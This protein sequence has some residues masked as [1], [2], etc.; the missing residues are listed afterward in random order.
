MIVVDEDVSPAMF[1]NKGLDLEESQYVYSCIILYWVKVLLC[2]RL[3]QNDRSHIGLHPTDTQ[4]AN[5]RQ[6]SNILLRKINAWIKVQQSYMPGASILRARTSNVDDD[7][8]KPEHIKLLLPS[9]VG[10]RAVCDDVLRNY[11][12]DHRIAQAND[13]LN[14]IRDNLC[15]R[16]HLYKFKDRFVRGQR[17]N[18]R[19]RSTIKRIDEAIAI[20]A[21]KYETAY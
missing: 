20:S 12:W 8:D 15:L 19:S 1:I 3:L 10:R 4:L 13:A 5:L 17:P 18:T 11:E 9:Q 7:V 21:T 14:E 6:R 16:T 2:R